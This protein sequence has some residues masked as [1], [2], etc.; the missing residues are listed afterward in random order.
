V[1]QRLAAQWR[2]VR[3]GAWVVMLAV[4]AGAPAHAGLYTALKI[5]KRGEYAQAFPEFLALAKLG[6]PVAQVDVAYMY[7]G[8]VGVTRDNVLAYAWARLAG[9]NADAQGK[10][11]AAELKSA[12]TPELELA[13]ERAV[14]RYTPAALRRRLLPV[15]TCGAARA[16]FG[17]SKCV[18][19]THS[20]YRACR[21]VKIYKYVYPLMPEVYRMQGQ[22]VVRFTLMPDGTARLPEVVFGLPEPGFRRAVRISV[23]RSKFKPLPRGARPMQCSLSYKF[24]EKGQFSAQNRRLYVYLLRLRRR[25]RRGDPTAEAAYGTLLAGLPQTGNFHRRNFLRWLVKAGQGGDALAQFEVGMSLMTGRGCLPDAAKGLRW[26]RLAAA[27]HEPGAEVAL[28]ARLLRGTLTPSA[29]ANARRW[30]QQAVARH[31][32][33]G[34]IYLSALLAAAP[35]ARI[36]DP[37][38]ALRLERMAFAGVRVDPTGYEIRAAAYAAEGRFKHAVRAERRAIAHARA[39]GWSLAPLQAR[40]QRYRAGKPWFGNLLDFTVRRPTHT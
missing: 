36:R 35:E 26:L 13:A 7:A 31:D 32:K 1:G 20:A 4:L 27:Q 16:P 24:V 6:Q 9:R 22:L 28:A 34:A 2:S 12:M 15:T 29:M 14:K 23:L 39:L 38:R 8:G 40:L 19:A 18:S 5:F 25:A 30:L 21:A 10:K 3:R 33:T 17:G 11:L 37:A